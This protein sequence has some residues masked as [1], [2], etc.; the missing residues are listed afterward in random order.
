M[1]IFVRLLGPVDVRCHDV[2]TP[3]GAPK[4]RAMLAVLALAANRPVHLDTL[5]ESLWG[6]NPPSSA[7]QN[8]PR[9]AHSLR[10]VVHD[11]L[12]THA[13][14]YELRLQTHELDTTLFTSLANRGAAA[15]AAGDVTGAVAA[16]GEALG[17]WRGVV[18]DGVPRI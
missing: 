15:L 1:S 18:L 8:L 14:A 17:L 16:Y 3:I 6:D 4:R 10:M 13:G 7:T 9:H 2:I 12:I 11:R 5:V